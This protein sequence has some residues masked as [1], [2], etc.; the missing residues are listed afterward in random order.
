MKASIFQK[1]SA[2]V[3]A[4]IDLN[5]KKNASRSCLRLRKECR[6]NFSKVNGI[7]NKKEKI[8]KTE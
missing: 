3:E 4:M 8:I 6:L 5:K 7:W 2:R 1:G